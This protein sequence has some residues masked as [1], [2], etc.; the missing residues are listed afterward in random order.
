MK[1]M[2]IIDADE[3]P[4]CCEFFG[5]NGNVAPYSI[6]ATN[7]IK[8][9]EQ[10]PCD[11]ISRQMMLEIAKSSKSNWIDNSVLF[12]RINELP[13]VNPQPK[14][15][16]W[17]ENAPEYQN[18][19]PPYIYIYICSECGNMHLRKTNYCDQCGAKMV[20]PKKRRCEE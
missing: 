2:A 15:G 11:A 5:C 13:Y 1:Y 6:G 10:G 3:K 18:I 14:T 4:V 8:A 16:R 7:N 12:K 9:F 20:E 19:D 17:I